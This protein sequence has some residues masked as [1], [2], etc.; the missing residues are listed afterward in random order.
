VQISKSRRCLTAAA[1]V[2][3]CAALQGARALEG[4]RIIQGKTADG[5]L[6]EFV[7][8]D[9][10]SGPV[11]VY[12]HGIVPP[13]A[14]V[15]LPG[16]SFTFLRDALVAQG[17][18]VAYSSYSENGYAVKDGEQRTHQLTGLFKSKAGRPSFV[19]LMGHSLGGAVVMGLTEKYPSQYDGALAM[20]GF[21][22]GGQLELNYVADARVLFDALFPGVLPGDAITIPPDLAANPA[23]ALAAAQAALLAGLADGR[24]QQLFAF[25]H[26]P[27]AS[28]NEL[29]QSALTAIGFNLIY[30]NDILART[31]GRSPFDNR[32]TDY[33][34]PGPDPIDSLVDR[35]A[36][37]PNAVNYL[38][39]Y[40]TPAGDLRIPMMTLH[41]ERDPVVPFF[42]E[43]AYRAVVDAA[44][45]SAFLRQRAVARY[46]HCTFTL[47]ETLQVFNELRAWVELGAAPPQ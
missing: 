5:A 17:V 33:G 37:H 44:G 42:H 27:G 30:T 34:A 46:G 22:G 35:F 45:S 41:T 20:C 13:L 9:D 2:A 21:L 7:V 15:A 26:L 32:T 36:S 47:P 18:A 8:P 11:V 6:Y 40:E 43:A 3:A 19:Y 14:P 1:V 25:A 28:L 39:R 4:P 29:L 38:R 12:A 23:P 24:T 10:W 31:Q 16:G